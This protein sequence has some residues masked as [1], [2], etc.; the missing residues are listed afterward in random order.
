[1]FLLVAVSFPILGVDFLH[2]HSLAVDVANLHLSPS[3]ASVSAVIAGRS[4]EDAVRSPLASSPAVLSGGSSP[5]PAF[6][7]A[8]VPP[9]H[10]W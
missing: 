6:S 4:Y 1:V 8:A 3:P 5:P 2:H 9:F 7:V 10:R